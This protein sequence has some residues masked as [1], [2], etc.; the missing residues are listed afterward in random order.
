[1]LDFLSVKSEKSKIKAA[2][3]KML[4]IDWVHKSLEA[5]E[6]SFGNNIHFT[7]CSHIMR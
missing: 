7:A 6:S 1:M 2:L 4:I 5:I 3:F